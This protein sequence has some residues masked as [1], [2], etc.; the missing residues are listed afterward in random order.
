MT[1]LW[2]Y[3]L[4]GHNNLLTFA[5]SCS[6]R[7]CYL[8][9]FWLVLRLTSV[10]MILHS[11]RNADLSRYLF[12]PHMVLKHV[13]PPG[14]ASWP[15]IRA[16]K[17]TCTGTC[18]SKQQRTGGE[19]KAK[20]ICRS[21]VRKVGSTL[22]FAGSNDRQMSRGGCSS[23]PLFYTG[24]I[25]HDW[26]KILRSMDLCLTLSMRPEFFWPQLKGWGVLLGQVCVFFLC[27]SDFKSVESLLAKVRP[28]PNV[29]MNALDPEAL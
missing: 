28:R 26:C 8:S 9:L 10:E 20:W 25:F 21:S 1:C 15:S 13:I 4:I 11:L 5:L 2:K 22:Q 18:V 27:A 12:Y 7:A 6:P 16:H 14:Q 17:F 23:W 24:Q 29:T 3:S 19:P